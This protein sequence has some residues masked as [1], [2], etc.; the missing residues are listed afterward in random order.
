ML[1][2]WY[3]FN[4]GLIVRLEDQLGREEKKKGALQFLLSSPF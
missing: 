3:C 2:F 4:E 1:G